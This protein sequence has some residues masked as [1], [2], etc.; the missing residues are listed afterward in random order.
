MARLPIPGSDDNTWGNIL[1]D[2]LLV[3][4]SS[5]GTLNTSAVSNAGAELTSNK[6]IASGYAALN[7]S[8]IVPPAQLG[9]GS[10]SSS[11][12]LRGDGTWATPPGGSATPGGSNTQLQYN[13]IGAFGGIAGLTTD[14]TALTVASGD[15]KLSGA[16]S[17][18]TT[19]NASATASG[20]LTLPATTDTVVGRATTDALTNKDL[21]SGTNT[22]PTF[23]QNTTGSAAKW[24]TPRLLAGNSVD[25]STNVPF[26]NKFIVQ[27]TTDSGLSGA[28]FL[29]SLS[30]GLLKNTTTTGVLSIAAAGTDYA[31]ATSGS[32]ILKGNGAGG[33]SNAASGTDYAPATSGSALL[34]GNG[35]GGFSNAVADT[36]YTTPAGTETL[37]NKR[38]TKRTGTVASSAT[39]TI[40]TDNVDFFSITAL[41][42]NIT[43]FTTNL[44]G[45]PTE[46]QTLWIAIT[47]NGTAR[48]IA[49]G[50]SFEASGTVALPT[51]TVIS[52][53]LDIGFVWNSATTKWRCVAVA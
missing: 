5:T 20:T 17:G 24:T 6:G 33:F 46:A 7:G 19:L 34:K 50:S 39:P 28:Q 13:N 42:T 37:T 35:A 40:N 49:F 32:A 29:G 18:T 52:T 14:G 38:I 10:A 8:G 44:S 1:N 51:T 26:A 41:S 21:T 11:T 27:G 43:S 3:S 9:T 22:F 36:D 15:L 31:P 2:Y 45:T 47:D 16:T 30:T 4:H 12:F 53:R 25:G 48:T 23:N